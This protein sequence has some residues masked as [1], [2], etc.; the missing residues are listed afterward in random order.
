ML[1]FPRIPEP[2]YAC[3]RRLH[4]QILFFQHPFSAVFFMLFSSTCELGARVIPNSAAVPCTSGDW[5]SCFLKQRPSC[6]FL[7]FL[8]HKPFS[9][10]LSLWHDDRSHLLLIFCSLSLPFIPDAISYQK[11]ELPFF[12]RCILRSHLIINVRILGAPSRHMTG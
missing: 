8:P 12:F 6:I 5:W 1:I 4:A 9:Q 2:V 10:F 7:W 3:G 11:R